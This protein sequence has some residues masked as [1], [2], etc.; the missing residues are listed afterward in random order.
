MSLLHPHDS[1]QSA[2]SMVSS[3]DK[4]HDLGP[5]IDSLSG[6]ITWLALGWLSK[7]MFIGKIL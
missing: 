3:H 5:H 6:F 1:W 4:P 2:L 7:I